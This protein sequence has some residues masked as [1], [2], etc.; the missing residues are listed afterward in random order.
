MVIYKINFGYRIYFVLQGLLTIMILLLGIQLLSI[1]GN[2]NDIFVILSSIAIIL[3]SIYMF[4]YC[5]IKILFDRIELDNNG[6]S[7]INSRT[8]LKIQWDEV[9]E[10]FEYPTNILGFGRKEIRLR[11]AISIINRGVN[12]II[13]SWYKTNIISIS[14]YDKDVI[15]EIKSHIKK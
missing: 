15:G 12:K 6:I 14:E 10:V 7:I 5:I 8:N 3:L 2:D 13:I 11:N 9:D 1:S 4:I